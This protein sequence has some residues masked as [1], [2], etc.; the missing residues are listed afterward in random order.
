MLQVKLRD[1]VDEVALHLLT[2]LLNLLLLLLLELLS[3]IFLYV[4][5]QLLDSF[6]L[7]SLSILAENDLL[8]AFKLKLL[9]LDKH[10][11]LLGN[12]DP[13]HPFFILVRL[14]QQ[15]LSELIVLLE[16]LLGPAK[17]LLNPVFSPLSDSPSLITKFSLGLSVPLH[18]F[19]ISD[20]LLDDPLVVK[21]RLLLLKVPDQLLVLLKEHVLAGLDL[22]Q[23]LLGLLD[24]SVL[25][26]E[27]ELHVVYILS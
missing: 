20:L 19:L 16:H 3:Q 17:L 13:E 12:F 23:I 25:L 26:V 6:S 27:Y 21:R 4:I 7:R 8:H 2:Q 24:V 11:F 18:G 15:R 9:L 1:F 5:I 14:S 22:V 10:F